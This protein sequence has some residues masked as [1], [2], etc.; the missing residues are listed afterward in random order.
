VTDISEIHNQNKNST[1]KNKNAFV[2]NF[3]HDTK[4]GREQQT[5]WKEP[6]F[7]Q[8]KKCTLFWFLTAFL[9]TY[10]EEELFLN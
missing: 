2:T 4:F 3:S 8:L 1:Y 6:N 10:L 9:S 5:A 7:I